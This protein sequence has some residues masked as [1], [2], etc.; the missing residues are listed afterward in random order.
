MLARRQGRFE[1]MVLRCV[2]LPFSVILASCPVS[3]TS[4]QLLACKVELRDR[5]EIG[6]APAIE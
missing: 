3:P 2:S 5:V 4:K 1:F 6:I